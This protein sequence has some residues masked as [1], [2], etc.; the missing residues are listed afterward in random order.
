MGPYALEVSLQVPAA[1][2]TFDTTSHAL[3]FASG[4]A[5]GD[6]D[7]DGLPDVVL[8]ESFT[9]SFW[10]GDPA[11]P[12]SLR[13][14]I[15]LT[16]DPDLLTA[17]E[18]VAIGDLDG[19]GRLEVLVAGMGMGAEVLRG[20]PPVVPDAPNTGYRYDHDTV[21]FFRGALVHASGQVVDM[22][23]DGRPDLLI[24]DAQRGVTVV[25]GK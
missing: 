24:A 9:A 23:A 25:W 21:A 1:P 3:D 10:R 2:G 8:A 13:S 19:D 15:P 4:G 14:P 11:A 6:L 12:G 7:R 18:H 20:T 17:A 5:V 16:E 22:N